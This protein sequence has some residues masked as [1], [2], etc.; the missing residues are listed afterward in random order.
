MAAPL[1]TALQQSLDNRLCIT[2]GNA[3]D[4]LNQLIERYQIDRVYWNACVE[5]WR[6]KQ[7][8]QIQ[9]AL[10][11]KGIKVSVFNGSYLW[12]QDEIAKDDGTPYKYSRP[13]TAKDA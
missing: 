5:P 12:S 4:Q 3:L 10:N 8:R 7:D 13:T 1:L 6:V 2:R 9:V 11:A